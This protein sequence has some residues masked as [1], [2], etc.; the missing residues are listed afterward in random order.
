ME[1][2]T[3][4]Y[5]GIIVARANTIEQIAAPFR[6]GK[7][8]P[9]IATL[10]VSTFDVD[11]IANILPSTGA[12]FL[13]VDFHL[14]GVNA[15]NLFRIR[16]KA[17]YPICLIALVEADTNKESVVVESGLDK[18]YN[19]PFTPGIIHTIKREVPTAIKDT[20]ANWGKGAWNIAP[21]MIRKAAKIAGGV[22]GYQKPGSLRVC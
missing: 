2:N 4:T 20:Q 3:P 7:E 13:M 10:T 19:I 6:R 22:D 16:E 14:E 12:S 5:E 18:V 11:Q 9:V 21:D 17:D 15:E 8:S 1:D